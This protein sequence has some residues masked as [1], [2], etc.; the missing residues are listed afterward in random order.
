MNTLKKAL[1]GGAISAVMATP[2]YATEL[3]GAVQF[4]D[5]HSYGKALREFERVAGE[6]SGGSLTFELH[7][8]SELGLEKDYFENMSQGIAVDYAIVSPSH[9]S[10]FSQMAP[11]MDMPFLFRD[12]DHW[13]AVMD[14]DALSPLADDVLAK[15]NVR[16][17]GY[18]GGGT[19]QLIVNRPITNMEELSGLP[20]RVMG[21][22]IQTQIFEAIGAA[23]SVIAYDEVY[24]AIQTGVIDGA[25]NEASGI[26]QMKFYEV[27]PDISLTQHAIT[28][29]P[30]AFSNATYERLSPEEQA[31][32]LEAGKA[33]G[34]LGR[35]LES[36][37]DSAKL[38]AMEKDGLLTTYVFTER[39]KLL[40]LAAPVKASYA[41]SLGASE[42][43]KSIEAVQ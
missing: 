1:L 30:I 5:N 41:E 39:D 33:A 27:G 31:C 6:C 40:E 26:E 14:Q 25:E 20:M 16:L 43:L 3:V 21:A 9:M 17:I 13:N 24:N 38:Q 4:D 11:L 34:K 15:A 18:A 35:E 12:L 42:V 23:P 28:V 36:G 8:N 32:V 10:T 19:R 37:Q 7:L 2:I 22:P 29:R